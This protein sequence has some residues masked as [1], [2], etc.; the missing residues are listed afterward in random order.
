MWKLILHV[1]FTGLRVA[2]R[3]G[4]IL[5]IFLGVSVRVFPKELSIW[6][7]R[8]SRKD[9]IHQCIWASSH[10]SKVWIERTSRERAILH[11]AWARTSCSQISVFFV[12]RPLDS[13]GMYTIGFLGSQALRSGLELQCQFSWS[14]Q[15]ADGGTSQPP[16]L[17]VC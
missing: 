6:I 17:C 15:T 16:Q 10:P 12:P 8:L 2:Q 13:D 5:L 4:K 1:N 9:P 7:I 14:L 11:S 3:G